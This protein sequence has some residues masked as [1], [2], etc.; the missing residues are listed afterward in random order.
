M[1]QFQSILR[2]VLKAGGGFA[3]AAGVFD[4]ALGQALGSVFTDL[5]GLAV[6]GGTLWSIFAHRT[7]TVA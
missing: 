4:P 5:G 2:T 6:A 3:V 1:N 7:K